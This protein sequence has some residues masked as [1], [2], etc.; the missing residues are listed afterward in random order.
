MLARRLHEDKPWPF[1]IDGELRDRALLSVE[2]TANVLANPSVGF[3]G[4]YYAPVT[5]VSIGE[6]L[7]RPELTARGFEVI[8]EVADVVEEQEEA[9]FAANWGYVGLG[10][11]LAI[12]SRIAPNASDAGTV[13]EN[14]SVIDD[15]AYAH[16]RRQGDNEKADFDLLQGFAGLGLY[17][18]LVPRRRSGDLLAEACVDWLYTHAVESAEGITWGVYKGHLFHEAGGQAPLFCLR[19]SHG[20]AGVAQFLCEAVRAGI[21]PGRTEYLL[22]GALR[23]I[24]AHAGPPSDFGQLPLAPG[25]PLHGYAAWCGGDLSTSLVYARAGVALKDP[26][27]SELGQSLARGVTGWALCEPHLPSIASFCHGASGA[28][29]LMQRW[30]ASTGDEVFAFAARMYCELALTLPPTPQ[31]GEDN[32]FLNGHGGIALALLT[33]ATGAPPWWNA[34][35]GLSGIDLLV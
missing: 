14:L 27:Y 7:G 31:S 35:I 28:L 3:Y 11:M 15:A 1:V 34:M 10:K 4:K 20:T 5:L 2:E 21:K 19:M 8:G 30:Y 6:A 17:A 13:L 25:G 33:A 26:R 9:A 32:T 24:E 22:R 16:V 18:L 29:H 12:M 23:W